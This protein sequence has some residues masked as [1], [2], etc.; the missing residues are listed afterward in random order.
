MTNDEKEKIVLMRNKGISYSKIASRLGISENTIKSFCKRNSIVDLVPIASI[1]E[2]PLKEVIAIKE[3]SPSNDV[4]FLNDVPP[5]K[6]TLPSNKEYNICNH[7]G[8]PLEQNPNHKAKKFCSEKCRY[9]WRY[10]Q[11]EMVLKVY[12]LMCANCG[13]KFMSYGKSNRKYC[14]SHC[15]VTHRFGNKSKRSKI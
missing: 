9:A 13:T 14:S 10:S 11:K 12:P 1:K 6:E 5:F 4:P 7:C 8:K 3:V 2:E 15:Y